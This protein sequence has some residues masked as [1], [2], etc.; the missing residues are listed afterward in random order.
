MYIQRAA[1]KAVKQIIEIF[2]MSIDV[3]ELCIQVTLND[4]Y[5]CKKVS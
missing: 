2:T 5:S 3:C 1:E 4:K